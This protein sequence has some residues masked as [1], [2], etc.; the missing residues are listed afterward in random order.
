MLAV[1][2]LTTILD[3]ET[4]AIADD[5]GIEPVA[6]LK[7]P[8]VFAKFIF[9][10]VKSTSRCHREDV[11]RFAGPVPVRHRSSDWPSLGLAARGESRGSGL[12]AARSS[13]VH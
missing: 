11:R 5:G 13:F 8:V 10:I 6:A 7:A 2:E 9:T 1:R 12:A 4:P 3:V